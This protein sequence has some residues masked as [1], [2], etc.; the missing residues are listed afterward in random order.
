MTTTQRVLSGMQTGGLLHLVMVGALRIWNAL[1]S[2]VSSSWRTGM[3]CRPT[4]PIPA[5]FA[6][7]TGNLIDWLAAG[8]DPQRAT[9]FIQSQVLDHAVLHLLFSMMIPVS[10]GAE[11]DLQGKTG[12]NQ[13][14]DL[15]HLWVSRLPPIPAGRGHSSLQA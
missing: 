1:R 13:K 3:P 2:Y 8:I 14:R 15:R 6:V 5:A 4:T 12:R 7:R 9:V 11:S 10:C